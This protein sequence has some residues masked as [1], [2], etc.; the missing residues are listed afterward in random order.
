MKK[1]FLYL[2]IPI[3]FG[4]VALSAEIDNPAQVNLASINYFTFAETAM[5]NGEFELAIKYFKQAD[6]AAPNNIYIKEKLV[7]ILYLQ[8]LFDK[9]IEKELIEL[10]DKYYA[11][12]LYSANMIKILAHINWKSENNKKAKKYFKLAIDL[13]ANLVNLLSYYQFQLEVLAIQDTSL[14]NRARKLT[15]NN[16]DSVLQMA[17]FY[18]EIDPKIEYEILKKAHLIWN[19]EDTL[20]ELIRYFDKEKKI[21]E[22][23]EIIDNRL[24]NNENVP[25]QLMTYY[26]E[27]LFE[28]LYFDKILQ[29][30]ERCFN[31]G[32]KSILKHMFVSATMVKNAE[33]G[34]K[35]AKKLEE[36]N[37]LSGQFLHFFYSSYSAMLLL[38]NSDE[39]AFHTLDKVN[40]INYLDRFMSY[41]DSNFSKDKLENLF[42]K[43]KQN[44]KQSDNANYILTNFYSDFEENNKAIE[45]L[46]MLSE[47]YIQENNL[48]LFVAMI[49]LINSS[50]I[51]KARN[52]LEN[53]NNLE[54]P[55]NEVISR[56]LLD[57]GKDKIAFEILL[58]EIENAEKPTSETFLLFSMI[59]KEFLE[60]NKI[61]Q[62]LEESL[63]LY[64]N[65]AAIMNSLA[66][67]IADNEIASKYEMAEE[68][69]IKATQIKPE[70]AM[71]WDSYAWLL[72]RTN[73]FEE[74]LSTMKIPLE[75]NL[76][77]SEITFHL[78]KIYLKLNNMEEAEKYF[79]KTILI[80]NNENA[81]KNSIELIE[82]Y[83]NEE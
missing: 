2:L 44:T 26:V 43:Y 6:A 30:A 11:E 27:R 24:A 62:I 74:A 31:I 4:G 22:I 67:T 32:N 47:D 58:N 55:V 7:E 65:N 78:G 9:N 38:N 45:H 10:G 41:F 82:K 5:Q 63:K 70:D 40:D 64:P 37:D 68:M 23:I 12:K 16:Q 76:Q 83:F 17:H 20:I 42:L 77:H 46:E 13:E 36:I 21:D 1:G 19:N 71:I 59:S 33:L 72:Y 54:I 75:K 28:F 53:S 61:I 49:Y 35:I 29:N 50:E 34:I 15:W 73:R 56:I 8:A 14:L 80:D 18:H 52:I 57:V 81:V 51:D 39:E 66:Y 79:R 3:F 48:Q 69:L 25:D 60:L